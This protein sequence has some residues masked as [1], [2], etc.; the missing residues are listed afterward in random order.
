LF[1][2]I[3]SL[4]SIAKLVVL[5][6]F[7]EAIW[8]QYFPDFNPVTSISAFEFKARNSPSSDSASDNIQIMIDWRSFEAE[9]FSDL[10][11]T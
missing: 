3:A 1:D 4:Q 5:S 10:M 6:G 9:L 7:L 2:K 11:K 8:G